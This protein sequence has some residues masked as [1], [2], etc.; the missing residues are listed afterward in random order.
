MVVHGKA[1]AVEQLF[2]ATNEHQWRK[3]HGDKTQHHHREDGRAEK[4]GGRPPQNLKY[5]LFH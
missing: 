1:F 3:K 5:F 2:A 4:Q